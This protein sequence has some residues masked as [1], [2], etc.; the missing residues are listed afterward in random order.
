MHRQR[1]VYINKHWENFSYRVMHRDDFKCRHCGRGEPDVVLQ[2]HHQRYVEGHAPWEY[3]LSD[4]VTLC[5]GCHAR[6]H[7]LLEPNSGWSLVLIED[8]GGLYGSCE[9]QGC[10][11][12]I[13]YAHVS[14]HPK[15]GYKVIGSSCIELLTQNDQLLSHEYIKI[16]KQISKYLHDTRWKTGITKKG[17]RY[18]HAEY[19]HHNIRIYGDEDHYAFQLVLKEKG[20]RWH[21]YRDV[22]AL[23]GK[24]LDEVK[25]LAFVAL[26]GTISS[27]KDE[28]TRLRDTYQKLK[29]DK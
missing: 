8:L 9:R 20:V 1:K 22:I 27:D 2:V 19:R 25:E 16:Y 12:E 23:R 18:L 14:Y 4:C 29:T 3:A 6:E 28:K 11:R 5:K 17:K 10:G 13:R 15:V 26:K 24:S 21:E 7:G